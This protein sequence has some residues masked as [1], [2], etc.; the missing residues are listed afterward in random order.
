MSPGNSYFTE[1]KIEFLLKYIL[2]DYDQVAIMVADIPAIST[3]IALGYPANR[4]RTDKAIRNSNQLKNRVIRVMKDNGIDENRVKIIDWGKDVE[5]N[6][7]YQAKYEEVKNLYESNKQFQDTCN[8]TTQLV[9]EFSRK[10]IEDMDSA[11]KTAVH[12]LLS[13]FAFLEFAPKYLGKEHVTY[14]YHNNWPVYENYLAG[15]FDG[16][17][18]KSHLGFKLLEHPDEMFIPLI[19][20]IELDESESALQRIKRTGLIYAGYTEYDPAFMIQDGVK[21]GIFHDLLEKIATDNN[22]RIVWTEE[23]GYGAILSSLENRHFDVFASTVWPTEE[24]REFALFSQ[25]LYKSEVFSWGKDN[26]KKDIVRIAVKENDISHSIAKDYQNKEEVF[27]E[28][29]SGTT[30][31]LQTV[32]D[33]RAD[34]TFAESN[35]VRI[36]NE[37]SEQKVRKA[38]EEPVRVYDNSYIFRKEDNELSD[39]FDKEIDR[40]KSN[41]YLKELFDK[42]ISDKSL[43]ILE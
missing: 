38:S 11:V 2:S 15:V 28:Q 27:V 26:E 7:E 20:D 6:I 36:F 29:L 42:Y 1:D 39:F 5:S 24:R 30:D 18:R 12:Y 43:F 37:N 32:V 33:G 13:E 19:Q 3:Y 23:V 35:T 34:I 40:L 8:K 22:F 25:P 31:L 17:E 4:A 14:V 41:G 16:K 21:V 9:L 10:Q